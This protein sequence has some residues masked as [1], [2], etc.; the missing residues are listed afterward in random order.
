MA[1]PNVNANQRVALAPVVTTS[2]KIV[3]VSVWRSLHIGAKEISFEGSRDLG[4]S[5]LNPVLADLACKYGSA[6]DPIVN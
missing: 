2:V 3:V 1:L 6:E 5:D 4:M